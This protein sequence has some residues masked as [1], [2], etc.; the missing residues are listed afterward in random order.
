[1]A[2]PAKKANRV[3]PT[4]RMLSMYEYSACYIV[5]DVKLVDYDELTYSKVMGD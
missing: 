3:N 2:S 5:N 1:M 4:V